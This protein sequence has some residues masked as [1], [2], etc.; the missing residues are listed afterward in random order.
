MTTYGLGRTP[1]RE[2]LKRLAL[3]RFISWDAHRTPYVKD[4]AASELARLTEARL[5][6]EVP[7]AKLAAER[8][9][10]SDVD[11]LHLTLKHLR[12]ALRQGASYE[13]AELDHTFHLT[14]ARAAQNPFLEKAVH[15]LT[16]GSL[17]LWHASIERF[18]L[19]PGDHSA[20]V[21]AVAAGDS[22]R[23]E[24]EVR[25]HIDESYA[26]QLTIYPLRHPDEA[27]R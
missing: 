4:I 3:E 16:C 19:P 8:A 25:R 10:R 26:N 1:L 12:D 2:A 21:E 5:V 15:D 9:S 22:E 23:A 27:I 17:R 7:I 20:I 11:A 14:I 18:G 6:L 24:A 13:A